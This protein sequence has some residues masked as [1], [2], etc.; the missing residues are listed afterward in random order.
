MKTFILF[1]TIFC[2]FS[3]NEFVSSK[4][5]K[6]ILSS[7]NPIV[8]EKGA[9]KFSIKLDSLYDRRCEPTR[10]FGDI[11]DLTSYITVSRVSCQGEGCSQQIKLKNY[12]CSNQLITPDNILSGKYEGYFFMATAEALGLKIALVKAIPNVEKS[13]D[14]TGKF[15]FNKF[16]V[17]DYKLTLIIEYSN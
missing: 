2:L 13:E 17:K 15:F 10:G 12:E 3:C 5:E 14:G 7:T 9:E 11:P 8:V 16:P 6:Q 1:L 4:N